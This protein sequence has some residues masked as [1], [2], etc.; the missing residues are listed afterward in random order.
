M[1]DYD[2]VDFYNK[3]IKELGEKDALIAELETKYNA[4]L[5][6]N[7]RIIKR[8]TTQYNVLKFKYDA[9]QKQIIDERNELY[10]AV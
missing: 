6:E 3:S 8:T 1:K 9:L 2:I 7:K 4:L 10:E 5:H